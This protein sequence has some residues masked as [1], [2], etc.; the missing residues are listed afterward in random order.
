MEEQWLAGGLAVV[1]LILP[2]GWQWLKNRPG[3]AIGLKIEQ[4]WLGRT[5][6]FFYFVGLPYLAVILG[7]LSPRLLGLKGLEHFVLIPAENF[8][9]VSVVVAT[10]ETMMLMLVD[11]L[12]DLG[13]MIVAGLLALII[14]AGITVGLTRYGIK[15]VTA[16]TSAV[17]TIYHA[18]HWAFYRAIFWLITGDLYLGIVLGVGTVILE[19]WIIIWL[20]KNW[21]TQQPR[22]LM[23]VIILILTSAIF[24]YRPNLWLL[25]PIHLAMVA[26]VKNR[27]VTE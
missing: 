18:L 11:W 9:A 17:D 12:A 19:W 14:L 20:Q 6:E 10:Q 23:D 2:A 8:S 22:R 7:L 26:L 25:W 3:Q 27:L 1:S 5:A 21:R 16:Q 4:R 24:F 13:L 15:Q